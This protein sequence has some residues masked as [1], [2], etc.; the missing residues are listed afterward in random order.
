[1]RLRWK[2]GITVPDAA[3]VI[4]VICWFADSYFRLCVGA[5]CQSVRTIP[6]HCKQRAAEIHASDE[7]IKTDAKA[8]LKPGSKRA[9]VIRLFAS[10][11]ISLDFYR[12]AARSVASGRIYVKGLR[13]CAS[14]ACRDDS[15]LI[16]DG[17]DVDE[18]GMV[19]PELVVIGMYTDCL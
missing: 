3:L 18:D 4:G 16:G 1:M 11:K 8:F 2:L 7:Q 17:A 6:I 13:E 5:A 14:A 9:D 10:E 19:L 15:A 12:I